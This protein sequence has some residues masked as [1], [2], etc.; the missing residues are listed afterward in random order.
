MV[1]RLR[2]VNVIQFALVVAVLYA[3]FGL[4]FALCYLPFVSMIAAM[5]PGKS[6]MF[7]AGFGIAMVAIFPIVYFVLSFVFGLITAFLYN[8]VAG[9]TGGIEVTLEQP[10]A[11][12]PPQLAL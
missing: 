7:G 6:G 11:V 9:W 4:I 3:I 5:S 2:H 8:L 1:T 10:A 12:A